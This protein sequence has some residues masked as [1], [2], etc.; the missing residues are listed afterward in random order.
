MTVQDAM[1]KIEGARFSAITNL[2]SD[3]RTFVRIL[4]DQPEVSSLAESAQS[5]DTRTRVLAR[6]HE[7]AKSEFDEAYEHPADAA[8]A[9]YLW[10]L[11]D[12]APQLAQDGAAAVAQCKQCWWAKELAERILESVPSPSTTENPRQAAFD[13]DEVTQPANS[14]VR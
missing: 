8:L 1:E 5:S 10:I 9:A 13:G 11:N 12:R 6:V 3:F 7:L 4:A 14:D 2:A